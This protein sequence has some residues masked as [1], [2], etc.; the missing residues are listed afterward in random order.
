MISYLSSKIGLSLEKNI[1]KNPS[2][3]KARKTQETVLIETW[4]W[5]RVSIPRNK[6]IPPT[7]LK[8]F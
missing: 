6:K 8:K 4:R 2:I 1:P 5:D 7:F 3:G